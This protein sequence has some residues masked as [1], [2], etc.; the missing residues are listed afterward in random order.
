MAGLDLSLL[1]LDLIG[2]ALALDV[3]RFPLTHIPWHGELLADRAQLAKVTHHELSARGMIDGPRLAAD[4]ERLITAYARAPLSVALSG[5]MHNRPYRAR[6]GVFGSV[7]VLA[8]KHGER[9]RFNAFD[10]AELVSRVLALVPTI[11]PGREPAV[12]ITQPAAPASGMRIAEDEDFA[13]DTFLEQ[14]R[15][16]LDRAGQQWEAV[17]RIFARP[18]LGSGYAAVFVHDSRGQDGKPLTV[19]WLDTDGGRYLELPEHGPDGRLH[20]SYAAAD[21]TRLVQTLE[22]LVRRAIEPNG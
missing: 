15:P 6:A 10:P 1:E 7:G 9:V 5:A 2:E 22:R 16:V 14:V 19:S 4:L 18:R 13:Q 3:R 12:T 17:R 11:R 20:I 21:H 8:E